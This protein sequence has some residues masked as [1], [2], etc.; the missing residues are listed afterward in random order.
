MQMAYESKGAACAAAEEVLSQAQCSDEVIAAVVAK[1][2]DPAVT[3]E[4]I[5]ILLAG[6]RAVGKLKAF[7][8]EQAGCLLHPYQSAVVMSMGGGRDVHAVPLLPMHCW[9]SPQLSPC[10]FNCYSWLI[11]ADALSVFVLQEWQQQQVGKV[12]VRLLGHRYLCSASSIVIAQQSTS[13][14]HWSTTASDG[15]SQ[16]RQTVINKQHLFC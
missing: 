15:G 14:A 8:G 11:S 1:L 16:R 10:F 7:A 4:D 12:G 6:P 13:C 3:V 9:V 5:T 2:V